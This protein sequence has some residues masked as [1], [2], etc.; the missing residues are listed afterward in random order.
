M[1]FDDDYDDDADDENLSA[2]CLPSAAETTLLLTKSVLL[3]TKI[4]GLDIGMMVM[5]M[6][7][8][9]YVA[10]AKN[11]LKWPNMRI[12]AYLTFTFITR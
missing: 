12:D 4:A 9:K 3:A 1:V 7:W 11:T 8:T 6:I 5:M 10:M 2:S